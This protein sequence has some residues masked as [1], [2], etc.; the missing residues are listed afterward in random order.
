MERFNR[1]AEILM[2]AWLAA[3]LAAAVAE[4]IVL[5]PSPRPSRTQLAAATPPAWAKWRIVYARLY[6]RL[7]QPPP[8]LGEVWTTRSGRICGLVNSKDT[9]VNAMT[10]FYSV[11]LDP[12]LR[13]DDPRRYFHLW[14]DC[15][16][17][18]WVILH[19]GTEQEGW[20]AS[21]LFRATRFGRGMC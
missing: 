6:R 9:A 21:A 15:A 17:T 20:C 5:L 19:Q 4:Q 7:P 14:M 8:E 11:G 16:D 13:T 12:V 3:V 18:P 10:R 1:L 2:F